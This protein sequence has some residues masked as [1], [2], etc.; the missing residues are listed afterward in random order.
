MAKKGGGGSS[1]PS[2]NPQQLIQEQANQN[3]FNQ[4]GPQ[5]NLTWGS[6]GANGQF[7]PKTGQAAAYVQESPFQQQY[8]Q[9]YEDLAFTGMETAASRI[10]NLPLSPINTDGLPQLQSQI[11]WSKIGNVPQSSDFQGMADQL[12][13]A[14]Y[15]AGYQRLQ[16]EIQR[17]ER[18]LEQQLSN[19]G[20]PI[21]GEAWNDAYGQQDRSTNDALSKLALDS[22][23]MGRQEQ[24]RLFG[25]DLTGR[26]QQ[27]QDQVTGMGLNNAGRTQGM[28][29]QQALRGQELGEIAS[30]L[31]LQPVQQTGFQ[32]FFQ[33]GQIDVTGPYQMQ[34]NAAMANQQAAANSSSGLMSG[35]FGLGAAG[36]GLLCWVARSVYGEGD[37]RW[38][39]VRDWMMKKAPERLRDL[40]IRHGD[41]LAAWLDMNPQHKPTVKAFFDREVFNG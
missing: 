11:D 2:I 10:Q 6:V 15:Q 7:Q 16:P 14:T 38:L 32:N 1:V 41:A 9:G 23:G 24:S 25:L 37:K 34:Q 31:G 18:R 13:D 35:L 19:R 22:V 28:Q 30:L 39:K 40:Y 21:G 20:L 5:G 3:R 26:N 36:I 8:R 27:L 29:E 17:Q 4:Y 33:P 12:T